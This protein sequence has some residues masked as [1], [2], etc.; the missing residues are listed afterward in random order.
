MRAQRLPVFL[1][2]YRF[3]TLVLWHEVVSEGNSFAIPRPT[4]CEL[5]QWHWGNVFSV[6][7]LCSPVLDFYLLLSQ[8]SGPLM[9]GS[10]F[11]LNAVVYVVCIWLGKKS[12]SVS[13]AGS[14]SCSD[15]CLRTRKSFVSVPALWP[16]HMY[17][18][19]KAVNSINVPLI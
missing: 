15:V 13:A 2:L 18:G 9:K 11:L 10:I 1:I 16:V 17:G 8:V 4:F 12:E 5:F 6:Q 7:S 3:V 14:F 19:L